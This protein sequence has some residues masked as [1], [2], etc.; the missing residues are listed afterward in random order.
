MKQVLV[1]I[2]TR[3][4]AF[5]A[6]SNADRKQWD[7][8]GP[9]F[10][11]NEVN[12]VALRN[13][14][15][16]ALF[17]AMKSAWWGPDL[18]LS[19][20]FGTTWSDVPRRISFPEARGGSVERI[21]FIE[22]GTNGTMYAG[23]DPAALFRSTDGGETWTEVES[24]A[25]HATRD[26]WQPGLGGLMAHT[27]CLD[28]GD[29]NR[30]FVGI[31]AV[32]VFRS[33]DGGVTWQQKNRGVL[34]WNAEFVSEKFPD[35]GQCPHRLEMHPGDSRVLY[36]QNH[37][38]VYRTE[39][40]GEEWTDISDG[41]PARFGFPLAVHPHDGDTIYVVPEVSYECRVT[42]NGSFRVYRSRNR[43]DS[44]QPLT[45]GLPQT[46]AYL[47]VFRAAMATDSLESPG[48]YVGTQNG[49]LF[50]SFDE[51]DHWT[52]LFNYLPPVYSVEAA[53]VDS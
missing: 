18:K 28:P 41:L 15:S 14:A 31:S 43:G 51:G 22:V 40:A 11:G 19:K 23:V 39:N 48:L 7:L 37:C 16:P 5:L 6:R 42:C 45:C 49:Q 3:K 4:G 32:G 35:I 36:Q 17:V 46:N 47:N 13:G 20:D 27:I 26:R 30:I 33:D 44:W 53:I 9:F 29:H 38:G 2:G 12:H 24:L 50:T 21:W 52:L 10:A 1:M 8:A 34:A 25:G